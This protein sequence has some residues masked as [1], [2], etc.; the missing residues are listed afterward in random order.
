V[1]R[2][3]RGTPLDKSGDFSHSTW[4]GV[5]RIFLGFQKQQ[6]VPNLL[7]HDLQ[8]QKRK[9]KE[10]LVSKAVYYFKNKK[11]WENIT[12]LYYY[13]F[14]RWKKK[15]T[16]ISATNESGWKMEVRI[17]MPQIHGVKHL[18]YLSIYIKVKKAT[19]GQNI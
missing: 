12:Q 1:D 7:E 13:I 6:E 9:S 4:T 2:G 8:R 18:K 19:A 16:E 11:E 17:H 10:V 14:K 5:G 3:W 15:R